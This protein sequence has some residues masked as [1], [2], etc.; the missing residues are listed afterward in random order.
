MVQLEYTNNLK[1]NGSFDPTAMI[2]IESL[3]GKL[4]NIYY[5]ILYNNYIIILNIIICI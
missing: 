1:F 5:I 2:H 4:I 3:G